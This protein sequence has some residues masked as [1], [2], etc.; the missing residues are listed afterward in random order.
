MLQQITQ[1]LI[2]GRQGF[3]T[4]NPS[5]WSL[6]KFKYSRYIPQIIN[7]TRDLIKH[8]SI[9]NILSDTI[10]S[11]ICNFMFINK[12]SSYV[13]KGHSIAKQYP[14]DWLLNGLGA[15][16]RSW[17]TSTNKSLIN[18]R[19]IR[20]LV[21]VYHD[22]HKAGKH[23]DLHIGHLSMVYRVSGKPFEN[24]LKYNSKGRLTE[25]SKQILLDHLK[26]EIA[27]N[28]RVVWNHDHT[29]S[30]ATCDWSY[31][32]ERSNL[33]GYGQ[34]FTRQVIFK[35]QCEFYHP[36]VKSSLHVYAPLINADQGLYVYKIHEGSKTSAPI[37]IVGTLIPRDEPFKDRLHLKMIQPEDFKSEFLRKVDH[38]TISRKMDGASCYFTSSGKIERNESFKIFSPRMSKN[39]S[40]R[41][42]YSY[43]ASELIDKPTAIRS[44]GMAEL[45][46]YRYTRIGRILNY[47]WDI[48]GAEN[49]CWSFL[50]A[51]QVA[52]VLN[53][54][55][56]RSTDIFPEVYIY[57]LDKFKQQETTNLEFHKNR[58]LQSTL[59]S[60]LDSRYWKIVPMAK[61]KLRTDHEGL[62]G[63][64]KG[65][66]INDG[67]KVKV[68]GDEHDWKIESID[69]KVTEKDNISGVVW[70]KSLESNRMYKLGPGN[71][72]D[73]QTCLD[74]LNNK[75]DYVGKVYKVHGRLGGEARAAKL[76]TEHLDKD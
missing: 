11:K 75:N 21:I 54:H 49:I 44:Q 10:S 50:S 55:K 5:L 18:N 17:I 8:K 33:K 43:K 38:G 41:I 35:D 61:A 16:R 26:N 45:V 47:L 48:K 32:P 36:E 12:A 64:P 73:K 56:V 52:G 4:V 60:V 28:S 14:K 3:L 70:F 9:E 57:R 29:L 34:G 25:D 37:L 39:T 46:F 74:M 22:A 62:V 69:L 30:N 6:S 27:K 20:P 71:L 23:I 1:N 7:I 42:E 51:S 53:S 66:S 40:H 15:S 2:K 31:D 58:Y 59:C 65:L 67:Y 76:I 72:G 68:W 13:N 24:D 63:V 19:I